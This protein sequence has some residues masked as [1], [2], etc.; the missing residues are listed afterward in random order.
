M[1]KFL[2]YHKD[3]DE[4]GCMH[5]YHVYLGTKKIG[6]FEI[7][8]NYGAE[9]WLDIIELLPD[10]RNRGFGTQAV[11]WAAQKYKKIYLQ[12]LSEDSARLYRRLGHEL[13]PDTQ[14]LSEQV[15]VI[16]G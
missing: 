5:C 8:E 6:Y 11:L 15:F 4:D 1:L 3:A 13:L 12:A 10:L 9:T 2:E 14:E 16:E 7:T